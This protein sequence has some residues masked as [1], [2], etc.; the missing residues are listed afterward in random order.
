MANVIRPVLAPEVPHKADHAGIHGRNPVSCK[1]I[2]SIG[3]WAELLNC[4]HSSASAS[5]I[6]FFFGNSSSPG[7]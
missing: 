1:G 3:G 5:Q 7:T 4:F 6:H 2:S